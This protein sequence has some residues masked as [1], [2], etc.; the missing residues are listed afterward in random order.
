MSEYFQ[1]KQYILSYVRSELS[2]MVGMT[3]FGLLLGIPLY[4][5][6]RSFFIHSAYDFLVFDLMLVMN[7]LIGRMLAFRDHLKKTFGAG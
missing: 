1:S 7:Y 2:S 5:A 6:T 3:V 4:Y